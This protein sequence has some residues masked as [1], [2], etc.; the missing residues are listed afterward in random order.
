MEINRLKNE[1]EELREIK[2]TKLNAKKQRLTQFDDFVIYLLIVII[3]SLIIIGFKEPTAMYDC[4][5][6]IVVYFSLL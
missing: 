2:E 6:L 1:V 3:L 4:N 5:G